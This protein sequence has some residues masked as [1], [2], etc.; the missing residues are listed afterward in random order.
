ML[1]LLVPPCQGRAHLRLGY[2][3]L[4]TPFCP[5]FYKVSRIGSALSTCPLGSLLGT[6]I[7]HLSSQNLIRL[8]TQT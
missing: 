2:T 1:S 6:E 3:F 4:V 8:T 7:F 5:P